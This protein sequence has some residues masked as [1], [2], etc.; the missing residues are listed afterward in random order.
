MLE[1]CPRIN[2]FIGPQTEAFMASEELPDAVIRNVASFRI[3]DLQAALQQ[4]LAVEDPG[5]AAPL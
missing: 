5:A 3:P 2:R 4:F 1:R